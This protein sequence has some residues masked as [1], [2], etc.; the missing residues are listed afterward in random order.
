VK[1][2]KLLLGICFLL[3]SLSTN[4]KIYY[5][6][7]STGSDSRTSTEAQNKLTPWK[8]IQKV[9]TIANIL[10]PGD[11][12]LFKRGDIFE[13]ML[14]VINSGNLKFP[15][16]FS[17]YG[18]GAKPIITG[19]TKI[20]DWTNFGD[21]IWESTF[22]VSSLNTCN[23]VTVNEEFAPLGRFP[24]ANAPN[25]G[26]LTYNTTGVNTR[27][28]CAALLGTNWEGADVVLKVERF[29]LSRRTIFAQSGDNITFNPIFIYAPKNNFGLF[30]Q[31]DAKTLDELNE[32][33][34]NA[35]TKKLR[36][37]SVG[38]P[39]NVKL[40]TIDTLVRITANNI[41][42][43]DI[44]FSG[45]NGETIAKPNSRSYSGI[46][47]INCD[48]K[49][50]GCNAINFKVGNNL[51]IIIDSCNVLNTNSNGILLGA[52][53]DNAKISNNYLQSTGS[54]AGMSKDSMGNYSGIL[55]GGK[56]TLIEK[57]VV[58]NTG[59]L[60]IAFGKDSS[61]VRNNLIDTFSFILDDGSGIYTYTGSGNVNYT[62]RKIEG[63]I[64]L[65]GIG[66]MYGA[67]LITSSSMAAEGIYLDDNASG[68]EVTGNTV[69]NCVKSGILIHNA[70][71]FKLT[72]NTIY[73]NKF[74]LALSHDY[75]GNAITGAEITNNIFVAK[76]AT[77]FAASYFSIA[78][79]YAAI[80]LIDRN[81]YTRPILDSATIKMEYP[82]MGWGFRTLAHWKLYSGKDNLSAVSK[83]K[84]LPYTID[85]LLG[86]NLVANGLFKDNILG[87]DATSTKNT[88]LIYYDKTKLDNGS[89]RIEALNDCKAIAKATGVNI[90]K[91]YRLTFTSMAN[92]DFDMEV[93]LRSGT[94]PFNT[95]SK[96][97]VLK[98][99]ANRNEYEIIISNPITN[100]APSVVF[101]L[102]SGPVTFWLDNVQLVEAVI[103]PTVANDVFRF[104]YNATTVSKKVILNGKFIGLDS[105]AYNDTLELAPFSSK[106][107][108]KV[109][110]I[111]HKISSTLP[112]KLLT[113]SVDNTKEV[114]PVNWVTTQEINSSYYEIERS[115]DGKNFSFIGQV[116]SNNK[117]TINNY[118]FI[119]YQP[120][121]G[122]TYYRLVMV[123][124]D[125][126]KSYS[127]IVALKKNNNTVKLSKMTVADNK[128]QLQIN[129]NAKQLLNYV[130][131]DVAGR[132]LYQNSFMLQK[133]NNS[134]S[135]PI[136]ALNKNVY[137][138]KLITLQEDIVKPFFNN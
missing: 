64:V 123:D 128:L 68:I 105:A 97:Q 107:L 3:Q 63:N 74:G 120:L 119:D 72:N 135:Q 49:Y 7:S 13:G 41:K 59:Y 52:G 114:V 117:I 121:Q 26:Y 38:T 61:I 29:I 86:V 125:G 76:D 20:T 45:S 44:E 96:V 51:N 73:N 53:C 22:S 30:I 99:T 81:V 106:V 48:I 129:C 31:N 28:K 46:A 92:T 132:L 112:V 71:N 14:T 40:S 32:W 70:R 98:I 82:N 42:I 136:D 75:Y 1:T 85:S 16:I 33:Y 6:S 17:A 90:S 118:Q 36:I 19:F 104:E 62:G 55:T 95:I 79:D 54:V 2:L 113:F 133:G 37:Y 127:N 23:M 11:V 18:V 134:I 25:G 27:V 100:I 77:K 108:L 35:N 131:V 5:V 110:I 4:A 65:N 88:S 87:M 47:I 126:S 10:L 111:A 138:L 115:V 80:G 91:K 94:S 15:I 43:S 8:T 137:Y 66:V 50:S 124:K 69:A 102:K 57:N 93:Y 101:S 24:N 39:I 116:L 67:G 21:N 84:L 103:K 122:T 58:K 130:I 34:Y 89:V 78:N 109:N 9:N 60:G 83:A 56:S 12:I